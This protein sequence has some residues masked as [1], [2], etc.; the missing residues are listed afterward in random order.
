MRPRWAPRPSSSSGC[1]CPSHL[2]KYS[3]E[4]KTQNFIRQTRK[5]LTRQ[6][7]QLIQGNIDWLDRKVFSLNRLGLANLENPADWAESRPARPSGPGSNSIYVWCFYPSLGCCRPVMKMMKTKK[8]LSVSRPPV[9]L[10]Q[11]RPGRQTGCWPRFPRWEQ[12]VS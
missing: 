12:T 11:Y 3:H 6:K 10:V 5:N 7:C 4:K 1:V 8:A 9:Q 2:L